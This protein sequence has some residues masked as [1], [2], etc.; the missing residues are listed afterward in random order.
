VQELVPISKLGIVSFAG[1]LGGVYQHLHRAYVAE[2]S[3]VIGRK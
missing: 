2:I 1:Q 3:R